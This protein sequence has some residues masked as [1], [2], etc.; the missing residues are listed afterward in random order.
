MIVR[1][2]K[3]RTKMSN[4]DKKALYNIGYGLYVITSQDAKRDNGMISNTVVQLSSE[5]LRIGVSINKCNYTHD[6]VR[7]SCRMN[8]M[9]LT[10]DTPFKVFEEFGFRS[11]RDCDKFEGCSPNR[12]ENGLVVLPK[13]INSYMS[14]EV[15]G[16][17]D[18]GSHGLFICS[19]TEAEVV[20]DRPSMSYAHYHAHV[21]PKPKVEKTKSAGYVC[22][23]CGYVHP[24][25][26]GDDFV[27]PICKHGADAFIPVADD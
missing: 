25:E 20:S 22:T 21:K 9:M 19:V 15:V 7:A 23:V 11:G 10:V 14:L 26:P 18:L 2:E 4:I 27:C 24:E 12:S 17:T 1:Q 8:V 5:P 6:T 16:Y 13:Y 3:R